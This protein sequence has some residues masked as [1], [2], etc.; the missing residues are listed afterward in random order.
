VTCQRTNILK[1][2]FDLIDYEQTVNTAL[3]ILRLDS[4]LK[5]FFWKDGATNTHS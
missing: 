5:A 3:S 2:D 1:V 4:G